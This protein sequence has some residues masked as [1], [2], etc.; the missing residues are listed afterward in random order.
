MH[1]FACILFD[2]ILL[3]QFFAPPWHIYFNSFLTFLGGP[4]YIYQQTIS[5]DWEI[6]D[7]YI[8]IISVDTHLSAYCLSRL[9]TI[10]DVSPHHN[11]LR[12]KTT[13]I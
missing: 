10:V 11:I 9:I 6:E 7:N 5:E 12:F 13:G 8:R 1:F 2:L 4:K 3:Y